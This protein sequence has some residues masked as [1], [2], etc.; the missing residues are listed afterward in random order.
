MGGRH[1]RA[2]PKAMARQPQALAKGGRAGA[3]NHHAQ[4]SIPRGRKSSNFDRHLPRLQMARRAKGA[5]VMF[6][7]MAHRS[8]R[9]MLGSAASPCKGLDGNVLEFATREEAEREATKYQMGI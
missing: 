4:L 6:I 3:R 7:I 2:R 1:D 8:A 5:R 9:S